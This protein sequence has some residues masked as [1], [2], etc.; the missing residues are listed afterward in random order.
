MGP[1]KGLENISLTVDQVFQGGASAVVVHKGLVRSLTNVIPPS[2]G[3]MIHVSGSTSLSPNPNYKIITGTVPEAITL[4]A[5]A[6]S[7]HVNVGAD[8]DYTMLEDL[9]KITEE[10]MDFGLPV[11]SM[12]YV[13]NSEGISRSDPTALAH[14]ARLSQELGA[15]IV[16]VN[17][18]QGGKDF[19][20]VTQGVDIPVIIAGGS[21]KND[22]TD[23][24]STIRTCILNGAS[25]VSVGRNIFQAADPMTAM[26]RVRET[27][28]EAVQEVG[29]IEILS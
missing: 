2:K 16:K 18:S 27:I 28:K 11:L 22:F 1:I 9:A 25:G 24:L 3:L 14:A 8:E 19:D 26:Q 21:I 12:T 13:R 6:I 4:G 7:C 10:A 15:D 20:E 17:A 23:L 29:T 5:D